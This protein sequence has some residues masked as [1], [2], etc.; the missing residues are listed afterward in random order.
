METN[1]FLIV[2]LKIDNIQ[3]KMET[4]DF[5]IILLKI[6]EINELHVLLDIK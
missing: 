2:L 5:S 3:W 4:N 1:D 6:M